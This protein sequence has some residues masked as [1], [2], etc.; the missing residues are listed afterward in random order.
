MDVVDLVVAN[1]S[2]RVIR[3]SSHF[4]F[5]RVDWLL[6][7]DR[8]KALGRRLDLPEGGFTDFGPH[9]RSVVRLV[10]MDASAG[11]ADEQGRQ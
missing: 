1:D 9:T 3:V 5:A 2:D 10:R 7:F 11:N 6:R 8:R 4:P